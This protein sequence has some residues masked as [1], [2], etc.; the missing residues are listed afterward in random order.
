MQSYCY[1]HSLGAGTDTVASSASY[2]D[3]TAA[4]GRPHFATID[5]S[6]II[7]PKPDTIMVDLKE[8][9]TSHEQQWHLTQL[10]T[11]CHTLDHL[12]YGC[13]IVRPGVLSLVET[14]C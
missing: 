6:P 11:K 2:T 3:A 10:P 5:G 9:S 7:S 13:T 4:Y 14:D 12:T 1:R 8:Q